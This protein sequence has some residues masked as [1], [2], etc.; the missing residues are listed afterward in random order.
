[1]PIFSSNTYFRSYMNTSADSH[2][3]LVRVSSTE[4]RLLKPYTGALGIVDLPSRRRTR[5]AVTSVAW[6][7]PEGRLRH[8]HSGRT[9]VVADSSIGRRTSTRHFPSLPYN[10]IFCLG[11]STSKKARDAEIGQDLHFHSLQWLWVFD[12]YRVV[13]S[14]ICWHLLTLRL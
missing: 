10:G 1:M 13:G 6:L 9:V 8:F 4:Y 3:T 7:C 12:L 2:G 5:R 11:N 14:Q